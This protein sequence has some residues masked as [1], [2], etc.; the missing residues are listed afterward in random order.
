MRRSTSQEVNDSRRTPS[1]RWSA[2]G[3]LVVWC[4]AVAAAAACA[5][6]GDDPAKFEPQL[7]FD[8]GDALDDVSAD[9]ADESSGGAAGASGATGAGGAETGGSTGKGGTGGTHSG[10]T[11]GGGSAGTG[12]STGTGGSAEAGPCGA[13]KHMCNGS[14]VGNTIQTG[15]WK[16]ATCDPC[17]APAA[18]GVA[19]CTAGGICTAQCDANY[20]LEGTNCVCKATC[21]SNTECADAGQVCQNG[22]CVSGGN[23]G[24]GTGGSGGSSGKNCNPSSCN[25]IEDYNCLLNCASNLCFACTCSPGNCQCSDC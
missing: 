7:K 15:C 6:G 12:G 2:S 8:S 5:T 20:T 16:S 22:V 13:A 1:A 4:V 19:V 23:G 3:A 11:N 24:S 18:N 25:A 17:P 10:G 14:C 21:C 9:Q